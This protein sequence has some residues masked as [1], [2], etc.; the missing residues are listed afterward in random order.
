VNPTGDIGYWSIGV[1]DGTAPVADVIVGWHSKATDKANARLIAA[2]PDLLE[3]A[4]DAQCSCSIAER[5]SGHL[6]GCWMPAL[7]AAIAKAEGKS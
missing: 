1:A 3:A 6:T 2:A 4:K 7:E 5:E